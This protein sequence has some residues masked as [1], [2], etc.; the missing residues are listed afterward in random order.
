MV[1]HLLVRPNNGRD[2]VSRIGDPNIYGRFSI[3]SDDTQV[4]ETLLDALEE[5][6]EQLRPRLE[7]SGSQWDPCEDD[8]PLHQRMWFDE[9]DEDAPQ[10]NA[11]GQSEP[12]VHVDQRPRIRESVFSDVDY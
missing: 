9:P 5:D 6:L 2:V 8:L 4:P 7:D 10:V 3:L 11:E 1:S 12:R